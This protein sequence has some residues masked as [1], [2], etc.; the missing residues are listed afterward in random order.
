MSRPGRACEA[1]LRPK[2][3]VLLVEVPSIRQALGLPWPPGPSLK[4]AA[5]FAQ[6]E[7]NQIKMVDL[8][9]KAAAAVSFSV[10]VPGPALDTEHEVFRLDVPVDYALAWKG[11]VCRQSCPTRRPSSASTRSAAVLGLPRA[12]LSL[13]R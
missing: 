6:A 3:Y 9:S 2:R 11:L 5:L 1:Q 13:G 8:T 12:P 7:V 10:M 4:G